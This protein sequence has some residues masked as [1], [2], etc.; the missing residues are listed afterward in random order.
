MI[1]EL[2]DETDGP[3]P[4]SDRQSE[5]ISRYCGDVIKQLRSAL[6]DGEARI[7]AQC[8]CVSFEQEFE[9][10]LV[11]KAL[12]NYMNRLTENRRNAP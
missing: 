2:A 8:A 9:S 7:I 12:L 11:K 4:P 10:P 1:E 5:L 3:S 6:N